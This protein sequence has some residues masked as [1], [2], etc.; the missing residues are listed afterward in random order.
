MR[1]VPHRVVCLLGLDDGVF[2]RKVDVDGDDL[3]AAD[4]R[5]GDRDPRSEDRQLLLDALLAAEDHLVITYS[6]R[7]ERTNAER[8]PAVPIGELLDVVDRTVRLPDDGTGQIPARARIVVHH[9]LQPF[10]ARN[11]VAGRLAGTA[12]WSFDAVALAG[13]R[14]AA[15]VRADPAPFLPAPLPPA[16]ADVVE[17]ENLVRFVQ[18]PVKA[19]LRQ[20]LGVALSGDNDDAS[21][22]LPVELDPLEQWAVGDRLLSGRLAGGERDACVAAERARGGLPPGTLAEPVLGRVL[23]I[24]ESLVAE[25]V[26]VT[27]DVGVPRSLEV[28]VALPG[29]R[30]LVGTVPGVLDRGPAGLLV[31]AVSYSRLAPKQRLAAWVRLL[32]LTAAHPD[33]A[34]E[35]VT[36]GRFRFTGRRKGAVSVARL[37][38]LAG[39]PTAR[40]AAALAQLELLVDLFDRGLREPLPLY[41]K[42]SAAW[43]ESAPASRAQACRAQWESQNDLGENR[44]PEHQLVLGGVVP[45]DDLLAAHSVAEEG[46][47]WAAGEPTRF[48]CYALR[49]WSGL[50]AAEE[51]Y[52]R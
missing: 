5:V 48:G 37:G 2:P 8:P 36:I 11:F 38:P 4:A 41:C 1:S 24:V 20:R 22:A 23:P 34:V 12:P 28:N 15:G 27:A 43:A 29:R 42:T 52:D 30:T 49:L 40:R 35:A 26:E 32:A 21:Q 13:A 33:R 50:L 3:V 14:A 9:P 51:V 45:F 39:D 47:G 31:R 7:D 6:G 19:F 44:D 46:D 25:A 16:P 10:D 18:H 17:L